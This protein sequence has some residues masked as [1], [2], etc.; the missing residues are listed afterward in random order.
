MTWFL[1]SYGRPEALRALLDAP[2]GMPANVVVLVN[3]DDPHRDD[4]ARLSPWP[5][6]FIPAGSR[7]ADAHRFVY[8]NYTN[9]AWYGILSD[10]LV[11]IT[12]G[13]PAK[14]I[15]AAGSHHIAN[16]RGGPGWPQ[17]I[18]SAV[19]FGGDLVREMG[20]LVPPGFN[21]NFVDDVWDLVGSTFR[22]IVPVHDVTIEHKH[23]IYGT[24]K[25]DA[26]YARGSADFE[27]DRLRFHSWKTG[28][29]W[30]EM[31]KR[32]A[33][34]TGMELGTVGGDTHRVA[35]CIPSAGHVVHKPFLRSLDATKEALDALGVTWVQVQR[36]GGS[37][38][39]K[40]REAV[41]WS[42]MELDVTHLFWLD[43]DMTW[44]PSTFLSLLS[45]GHD[46]SA[47]VGMRKT[48]P[49]QPACNVLPGEQVFDHRTG[50]L[51]VRDVGFAFVCLTRGA[52]ERMCEA[53]PELRYNTTDGSAQYA[54]FLDMI[55]NGERMSEDFSFCRRWR[56]MGGRIWLD[57]HAELG[58]L[59][60]DTY[61]GRLSD[62]FQYE[63]PPLAM[64]AE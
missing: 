21:H 14:M 36:D 23:P 63:P 31:A 2:G 52:I 49:V 1:P 4:Y 8:E 51:E 58:H 43:D 34:L 17:K 18:R 45:S 60:V 25:N 41:L 32:V 42:A 57:A 7:A 55:D 9:E 11:P 29:E 53:H 56:A 38:V 44:E 12:P 46:F 19:C 40:A 20:G 10:D 15:E 13:W 5:V 37:H 3:E 47:V 22:L 59:G 33:A 64:A 48:R 27:A 35:L 26:T 24:A 61:R 50:F 6:R 30:A 16:P 39:G 28:G 54:L 62:F